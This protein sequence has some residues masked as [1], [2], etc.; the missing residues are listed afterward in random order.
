MSKNK[1]DLKQLSVSDLA[2]KVTEI[3]ANMKQMSFDHAIK[4]LPNP[5]VLRD[6]RK[7]LARVKTEIRGRELAELDAV[8]LGKRDRLRFRRK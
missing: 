2:S 8:D 3:E 1:E 5:I 7:N 6:T 4:G